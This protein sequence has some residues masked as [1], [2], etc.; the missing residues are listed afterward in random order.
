MNPLKWHKIQREEDR[1]DP[2]LGVEVSS[3]SSVHRV[4]QDTGRI[5]ASFDN[6]GS[7]LDVNLSING[8]ETKHAMRVSV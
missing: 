3:F 7:D 2:E 6:A 5:T 1:E 8:K 4:F